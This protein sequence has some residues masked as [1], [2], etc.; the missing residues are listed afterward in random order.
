[1]RRK[2][3]YTFSHPAQGLKTMHSSQSQQ[4]PG[5]PD[6]P[7]PVDPTILPPIDPTIPPSPG[8]DIPPMP[9]E[10]P[11]TPFPVEEPPLDPGLPDNPNN[12]PLI[13]LSC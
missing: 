3:A 6:I 7:V 2:T 11:N 5:M 10:E 8:P 1:L 4:I 12:G 13:A 9:E